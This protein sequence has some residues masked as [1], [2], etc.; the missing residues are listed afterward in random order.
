MEEKF[1]IWLILDLFVNILTAI[2]VIIILAKT[3]SGFFLILL[4]IVFILWAFR[5]LYLAFKNMKKEF[6]DRKIK[7]RKG[8][9]LKD[10]DFRKFFINYPFISFI[11][12]III[13]LL[14]TVY[15]NF[16]NFIDLDPQTRVQYFNTLTTLFGSLFVLIF[17]ISLIA[18][19]IS[20]DKFSSLIVIRYLK[21]KA[22]SASMISFIF[23][24]LFCLSSYFY[25]NI[26]MEEVALLLIFLGLI[27]IVSQFYL[28]SKYIDPVSICKDILVEI[29]ETKE[30]DEFS[31]TNKIEKFIEMYNLMVS[32]DERE[33]RE[34]I[35]LLVE[36]RRKINIPRVKELV[37]NYLAV[38][39]IE[40]AKEGKNSSLDSIDAILDLTEKEINYL[41]EQNEV[42]VIESSIMQSR[43][44]L[45]EILKKENGLDIN[46][47]NLVQTQIYLLYERLFK[48]KNKNLD[49]INK[50]QVGPF[51]EEF[52]FGLM[53]VEKIEQRKEHIERIFQQNNRFMESLEREKIRKNKKVG[54]V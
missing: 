22:V 15:P 20:S 6:P 27:L 50:K 9:N 47:I 5:P 26:F 34:I 37:N 36:Y 7:E 28:V 41:I 44:I 16:F 1:G 40:F 18:L 42:Y 12:G 51:L 11:L 29:G 3:N 30:R 45:Q 35:K 13:L 2:A 25:S 38:A 49:S 31:D 43:G 53:K 33:A 21:D 10:L 32:S 23:S 52:S 48:K 4:I 8:N 46:R 24:L 14:M 17:S 54:F 39:G 19:Q